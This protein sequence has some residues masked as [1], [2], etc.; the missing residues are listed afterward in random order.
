MSRQL[1][2]KSNHNR[3]VQGTNMGGHHQSEEKEKKKH[4]QEI[5]SRACFCSLCIDFLPAAHLFVIAS[6]FS[7]FSY[8][9]PLYL[10]HEK[11]TQGSFCHQR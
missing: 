6:A 1:N 10:I 11:K 5:I 7:V 8:L 3:N 2:E 9:A 4:F